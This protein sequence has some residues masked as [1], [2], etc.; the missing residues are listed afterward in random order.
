MNNN[1]IKIACQRNSNSPQA[2]PTKI[3]SC[4][5]NITLKRHCTCLASVPMLHCSHEAKDSG[6]YT[7]AWFW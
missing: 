2:K 4:A 3:K 1:M 7:Y 6:C 5:V